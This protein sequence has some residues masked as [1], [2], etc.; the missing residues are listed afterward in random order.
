VT[1]SLVWSR[2]PLD[3]T[4]EPDQV[5]VWL[6]RADARRPIET[7]AGRYLGLSP[8]SV[9]LRRSATGKPEL[10]GSPLC[11]SLAHSGQVAL[12]AVAEEREVGVDIERLRRGT[13]SWSLVAHALTATERA[14]LEIL[15][16]SRRSEAFLSMWTRKEALLKAVGV[17]QTVDPQLVE[18]DGAEVVATPPELGD[19]RD[20]TL[21][22]LPL[23][24]HVAALALK[25]SLSTIFLYDTRLGQAD[26][27]SGDP[28]RE[29]RSKSATA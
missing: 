22:E 2:P 4:L 28:S 5:A 7:V 18:L 21:V 12:V 11:A 8:S 15:P 3:P 10:E 27:D 1:S 16:S 26:D 9:V 13:E 24:G 19:P 14:S 23:P 6:F 25:G 17:G 29:K 20:W